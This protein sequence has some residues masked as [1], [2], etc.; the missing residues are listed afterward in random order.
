M[1]I[2]YKKDFYSDSDIEPTEELFFSLT[3]VPLGAYETANVIK[4]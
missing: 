4:D 3:I 1:Q 2:K